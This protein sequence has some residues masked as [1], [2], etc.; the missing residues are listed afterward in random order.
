MLI[1]LANESA[2]SLKYP[3]YRDED[4][5]NA[6]MAVISER[7][8]MIQKLK[9]AYRRLATRHLGGQRRAVCLSPHPWLSA[10]SDRIPQD[11]PI[12]FVEGGA[13]EGTTVRQVLN[14]FPQA[15]VHAFEPLPDFVDRLQRNLKGVAGH[16]HP[17]A[18][19]ATSQRM[20]LL[21]NA[22]PMTSS[23]LPRGDAAEHYY[24][25]QMRTTRSIDVPAIALDQWFDQSGLD[26]VDVLKLG[27]QGYELEALRGAERLLLR[28]IGCLFVEVTFVPLYDGAPTFTE[29][30]VFLRE[31]G[32]RLFNLYN[33]S[34][35]PRDGQLTTCD[36]LY[37]SRAGASDQ[38]YRRAA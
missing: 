34:T 9:Q 27:L 6:F 20:K 16:V 2:L 35:H 18:L 38:I 1:G 33:L 19:A 29:I 12:V 26:R 24:G 10:I 4:E 13:H 30:D 5:W 8:R 22:S 23:V 21:V 15:T 7:S 17:M 25:Q 3:N 11:R 32:Y 14:Q 28:G 37:V 31:R 36:A